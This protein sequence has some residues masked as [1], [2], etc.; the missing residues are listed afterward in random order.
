MHGQM[1]FVRQRRNASAR[2]ITKRTGNEP[3]S[4]WA[5]PKSSE[6]IMMAQT[7]DI[8]WRSP[9]KTKPLKN[10]SSQNGAMKTAANSVAYV[11][12]GATLLC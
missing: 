5:T 1:D 2:P 8:P 10:T 11:D 6:L 9:G 7:R 4:A 12:K 3:G